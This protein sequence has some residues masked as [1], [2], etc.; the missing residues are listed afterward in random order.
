MLFKLSWGFIADALGRKDWNNVTPYAATLISLY[1]FLSWL[2]FLPFWAGLASF[3]LVPVV[4]IFQSY[5]TQRDETPRAT[6]N[7]T[8]HRPKAIN[9]PSHLDIPAPRTPPPSNTQ[10]R[11]I[12][13]TVATNVTENSNLRC[14]YCASVMIIRT[15]KRGS[16]RGK[17]FYGCSN[18]PYC[19]GTRSLAEH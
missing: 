4:W 16:N 13:S 2:G 6:E 5:L 12:I 1:I 17:K 19:R 11:I 9:T 10:P 18:F 7:K 14:P 3:I 8:T 15:A